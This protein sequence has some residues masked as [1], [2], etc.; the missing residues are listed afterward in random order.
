MPEPAGSGPGGLLAVA[1]DA[2]LWAVPPERPAGDPTGA[3]AADTDACERFR[4]T[5]TVEDVHAP[6]PH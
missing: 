5:V 3:G 1:P 2:R 6:Q 4:T